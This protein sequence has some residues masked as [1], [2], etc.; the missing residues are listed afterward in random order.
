MPRLI[1]HKNV[2][3]AHK[4]SLF[5]DWR[6]VN[7]LGWMVPLAMTS[8][9]QDY[10]IIQTKTRIHTYKETW[11]K[12]TL[13]HKPDGFCCDRALKIVNNKSPESFHLFRSI[14]A[15]EVAPNMHINNPD[16]DYAEYKARK[17]PPL[18][19]RAT[20]LHFVSFNANS[21]I[22]IS[23]SPPLENHNSII[24]FPGG[25]YHHLE[26]PANCIFMQ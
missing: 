25:L 21:C 23:A 6:C 15:P 8:S 14:I 18:A 26:S 16:P 17:D 1:R 3:L 13:L 5:M 11:K 22:I 24:K 19:K 2:A 4:I 7:V 20:Y 10:L 12:P 9:F